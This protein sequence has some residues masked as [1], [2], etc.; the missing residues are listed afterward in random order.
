MNNIYKFQDNHEKNIIYQNEI[1]QECIFVELKNTLI[2]IKNSIDKY[3]KGDWEKS[4]KMMTKYELVYSSSKRYKNICNILPVSR[5]YFKLHQMIYDFDLL[6][7][8]SCDDFF[9]CTIA[10]GPG[11][12]IHC[13][14]DINS[15][16]KHKIKQ[17]Y[18][19]TLISNDKS[20]P[21]WNNSILKHRLNKIFLETDGNIYNYETVKKF[22]NFVDNKCD[23][24]TSD[25]GFDYSN[26]YNQQ[27]INSYKLLYCEIFIGLHVQK[28]GGH[29]LIKMFD[30]MYHK[31]IQLIYL[32][33]NLY[34]E[35]YIYKP[36]LSRLSNSE[37][38][39]ICK[40]FLGVSPEIL[41]NMY[42]KFNTCETFY[43]KIP[44]SFLNE[45]MIYNHNYINIQ[46]INIENIINNIT[47]PIQKN[48]HQV[49]D[50]IQWCKKYN[51]PINYNCNFIKNNY[52]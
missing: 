13:L 30:I 42:T 15:K 12:F 43:I 36:S 32:L 51:L 49:T 25:G 31:T 45:M 37:K 50:A 28:E 11:G 38:Y 27:E 14:N 35:V 48:K 2:S 44:D 5:S 4:K 1:K 3:N 26:N 29:F 10:E 6:N 41:N 8:D 34:S 16:Y 18:G 7:K 9:S 33:Y 24:I 40:G 20:V 46:K 17:I 19:I 23:L 21:Y 22:I 39:I 47:N 52:T